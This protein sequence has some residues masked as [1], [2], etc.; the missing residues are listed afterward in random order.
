MHF[1]PNSVFSVPL[2]S[3]DDLPFSE[4]RTFSPC[5]PRAG[6]SSSIRSVCWCMTSTCR[7]PLVT[8]WAALCPWPLKH[9]SLV[10]CL[11][12]PQNPKTTDMFCLDSP[13]RASGL[14]RT[15][16]VKWTSMPWAFLTTNVRDRTPS[17]VY[18]NPHLLLT[19]CGLWYPRPRSIQAGKGTFMLMGLQRDCCDWDR[20]K[21]A[22]RDC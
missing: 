2:S 21:D 22:I 8:V 9:C 18:L 20:R 16:S 4:P 7:G 5:L 10:C 15:S 6:S 14:S 3:P 12:F 13:T 19:F 1:Q 17:L 11:S